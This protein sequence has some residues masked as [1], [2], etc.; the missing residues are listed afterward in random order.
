MIKDNIEKIRQAVEKINAEKAD[1]P[2]SFES[3]DIP[4]EE[5]ASSFEE[6]V[7]LNL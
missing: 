1:E 4:V 6:V 2:L 5:G 7:N 3:L